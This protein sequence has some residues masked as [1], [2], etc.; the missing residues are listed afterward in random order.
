VDL[1]SDPARFSRI[2]VRGKFRAFHGRRRGSG[3]GPGHGDTICR[4]ESSNRVAGIWISVVYYIRSRK[5]RK[6]LTSACGD[7]SGETRVCFGG[8]GSSGAHK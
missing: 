4:A 8:A 5:V 3:P 7:V 2:R 1:C 6:K